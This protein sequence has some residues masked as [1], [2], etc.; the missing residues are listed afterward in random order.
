LS[1]EISALYEAF[2]TGRPSP[3][4][5][6]PI[7][8][9]DFALWQRQ[10]LQ[11]ETL[12]S[13]LDYWR[14]QLAALP[15][16][17]LPADRV[18]PAM[19]SYRGARH[20]IA[21]PARLS[22]A[23]KALS[24]KQETTLFMTLL[25]AFQTLLHRYT[26][27]NNIVVGSPVAGRTRAE[28][29]EL[30][31][32]FVNTLVL[33]GDLSGNP[34]FLELLARVRDMAL[35]AYAHQDLPFEKLVEELQPERDLSRNPLFQ[36][37]FALQ[38]V[39]RQA[40]EL[41]GSTV[42]PLEMES[43]MAKFDL[44]LSMVEVGEN[45][46]GS[47]EYNTDLFESATIARMSGHFETLL[48]GIVAD[49][50]RRLSEL[51]LLT[52]PER[53]QLLIQWNDTKKS[54]PAVQCIHQLFETQAERT[55]DS[56]AVS[57]PSTGFGRGEDQQLTYR[58]LNSRANQLA[59]HLKDLGVGRGELVG[60]CVERSLEMVIG[61]LAILK[62]G[63]AYV[64]LDPAYPRERLA[65]M[66][67]DSRAPVLLTQERLLAQLP[68]MTDDSRRTT[69]DDAQSSFSRST[70]IGPR[71]SS[72]QSETR[73][74]PC[75]MRR[76]TVICLD[77]D[78]ESI[79]AESE[80]NLLVETSP[81]DLAYVIFTSGSTGKP[82]GVEISHRAVVNFL[83]SMRQ[84]PGLTERDTLLSVTTLSFDIAALEIFLPLTVGARLVLVSWE[85]AAD[86]TLL[87]EK[88]AQCGATAMQATPA[89]WR[90]LLEA[91][92]PGGKPFTMLCG[93]EA[94]SR[95]LAAAL[96]EKGSSLWN[97]YGPTETT[98]WSTLCRV[99]S[100]EGR[101]P[102]GRP[103]ANTEIYILDSHLQPVPIGIP[104]DLYI[105]GDGLARGYLNR[106]DLTREKFIP[107]PFSDDPGARLY[108][109]GD[110]ARYLPDG[111]IE[112]LGRL[113]HQV[114]LRGFRIELGEIETAL[115]QHP[116]VR[117]TVVL[118]R[119]EFDNPQSTVPKTTADRRPMTAEERRKTD[120]RRPMTED[121]ATAS[122]SSPST[123]GGLRSSS[124]ERSAVGGLPSSF[125]QS[126][127]RNPQS[128]EKRLVA[129]VVLN[130]ELSP[131]VSE[132]RSFLKEKLPEYMVPS[133]FVMLAALPLTPNGK[134]DRKSLPAPDRSRPEQENPFVAP[135]T[136]EETTIADIWAKVLKVDR[137]GAHDNFFD[138]GGHSLLATQVVSRIRQALDV[139]L[140]LRAL[141]EN[142][143]V[144]QLAAVIGQNQAE[145]ARQEELARMLAGVEALSDDEAQ[146][147]LANENP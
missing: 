115:A 131:S 27:Q 70:V 26:R 80:D 65:F 29:E 4:P 7:Q 139:D 144:E 107:H 133:A 60:I 81:D 74:A 103:I 22:Q 28:T 104:G 89:T 50:G 39:P 95:G 106:P 121:N 102:I 84:R 32:F 143:T 137:V 122:F 12:E 98:I 71:S 54:Y 85:T 135:S 17:E 6:L 45:L 124:P 109:T 38:N 73:H 86:G 145:G 87:A 61:L 24:R 20:P 97:L 36:V 67:E 25:A 147:L 42:K 40:L 8:Y 111:N 43:R 49:P 35:G 66:L 105:G 47:L 48:E 2:S 15:V 128:S 119:E 19:Q 21:L 77:A 134:V 5:D 93:G 82:K 1:R 44:A 34:T 56:V 75:A 46:M 116:A 90:L 130:P 59:H 91:G 138:L 94:L 53:Q 63:G 72:L 16:L 9:P 96:M 52:E 101:I 68:K 37:W 142:P 83:H 120:D 108:K 129:Y 141:F 140:P 62:A 11:G 125:P 88:L 112:F 126:A 10:Y 30:I 99:D 118:A 100:K 76:A 3:L 57:F 123:V 64:P 110:L 146:R 31:G 69:D 33:H 18:R 41:A 13:Q 23:L 51:P 78:W 127:I 136:P 55:P 114:K 58:E 132:L 79:A 92:W 113:D 14:Q 117:E